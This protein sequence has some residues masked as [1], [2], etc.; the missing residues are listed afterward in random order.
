ME[1]AGYRCRRWEISLSARQRKYRYP[2]CWGS[3]AS[4]TAM[5]RVAVLS[6]PTYLLIEE[7]L[8]FCSL[9]GPK[10]DLPPRLTRKYSEWLPCLCL[11]S[12]RRSFSFLPSRRSDNGSNPLDLQSYTLNGYPASAYLLIEEAS[13]F[14]SL[15]G[16]TMD[17]LSRLTINEWISHLRISFRATLSQVRKWTCSPGSLTMRRFVFFESAL[18]LSSHRSDNGRALSARCW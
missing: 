5:L 16:P 13:A 4:I 10:M 6:L 11:P 7:A 17:L 9:A 15:S 2:L 8:A 1:T 18:D 14:C 3:A 12:R